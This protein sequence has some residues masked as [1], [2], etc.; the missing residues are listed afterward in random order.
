[1]DRSYSSLMCRVYIAETPL[2]RRKTITFCLEEDFKDFLSRLKW[3]CMRLVYCRRF[4]TL[5]EALVHKWRLESLD[6]EAL[7]EVIRRYNPGNI[8]LAR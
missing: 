5:A 1:M 6:A 4:D 8:D 3:K 2:L 7:E